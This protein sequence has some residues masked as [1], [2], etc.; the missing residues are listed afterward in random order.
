MAD[1]TSI[2]DKL[3][4]L[5]NQLEQ[6]KD[7]LGQLSVQKELGSPVAKLGVAV[8]VI[9]PSLPD[10]T[11]EIIDGRVTHQFPDCCAVGNAL[12]YY[13]SGTLIAPNVVVTADHCKG[14]SRVFLGGHDV[15]K[16]SDGET[17]AV[18]NQF[19]HRE[20]DLRIL[21]LEHPSTVKPRPVARTDQAAKAKS[22]ML[23]GFGTVD[24]D[25]T[26]GYGIKR[27]LLKELP[28]AS[29]SCSDP[30]DPK[31]Y[32]CLPNRE[33]VAGHR[34]LRADSCR[35]DSGG[36]LYIKDDGEYLLLGVTSRGVK[37][38]FTTCGDG[39]VYVRVD[40]CLDWIEEVAG[41]K[42]GGSSSI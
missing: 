31:K 17:I 20:V 13:C 29:I 25:G 36:P 40:L 23:A 16:P 18:K 10:A 4:D 9:P 38:G 42:I 32:G 14:V 27:K 26:V 35:G 37:D 34:G 39:G 21:I 2:I 33:I 7:E 22:A 28:I 3:E 19:S 1:I 15:S 30:S 41:F 5:Q 12:G 8:S 11:D 24:L 6:L